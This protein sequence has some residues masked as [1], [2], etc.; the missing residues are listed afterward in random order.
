M[1]DVD[2]LEQRDSRSDNLALLDQALGDLT[3]NRRADFSV[4]R[5][6]G[7]RRRAPSREGNLRVGRAARFLP[8][9][10]D[11]LAVL[12]IGRAR[13]G[14]GTCRQCPRFVAPLGGN[15]AFGI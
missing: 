13:I 6:R 5:Q 11:C 7:G 9:P 4:F 10:R 12:Q 15:D 3:G 14:R 8:R 2:D 1:V